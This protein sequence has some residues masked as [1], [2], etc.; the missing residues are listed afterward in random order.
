MEDV[1]MSWWEIKTK[2]IFQFAPLR[3]KQ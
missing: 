3:N 1:E 2:W